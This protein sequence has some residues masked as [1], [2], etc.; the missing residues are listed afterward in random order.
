MF[1]FFNK[2]PF[3]ALSLLRKGE[4]RDSFFPFKKKDQTQ[5]FV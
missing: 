1:L 2:K 5:L 4:V 3:E